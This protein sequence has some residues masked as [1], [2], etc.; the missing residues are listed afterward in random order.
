M[1]MSSVWGQELE[2]LVLAVPLISDGVLPLEFVQ[3]AGRQ[4]V[5]DMLVDEGSDTAW[6]KAVARLVVPTVELVDLLEELRREHSGPR[7]QFR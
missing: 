2:V 6:A 7:Q 4:V 5:I 1:G 3:D